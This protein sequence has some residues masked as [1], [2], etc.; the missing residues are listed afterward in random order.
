M[1]SERLHLNIKPAIYKWQAKH[2]Q[3][4]TFEQLAQKT[5]IPIASLYRLVGD[6]L[7]EPD[8]AKL[9][10]LCLALECQPG[11]IIVMPTP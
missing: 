8:F 6:Q 10:R 7:S 9:Y 5:D 11:D 4:L 2:K 1:E 3:R